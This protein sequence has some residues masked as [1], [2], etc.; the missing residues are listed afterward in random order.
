[1]GKCTL[2]MFVRK[3]RRKSS[4]EEILDAD[5]RI[6]LKINLEDVDCWDLDLDKHGNKLAVSIRARKCL[7]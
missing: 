6:I 7:D 5:L 1:M 4:T 2:K 3:N